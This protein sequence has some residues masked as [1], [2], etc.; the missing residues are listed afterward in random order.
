MAA[1]VAGDKSAFYECSFS[2][3]Q[4]TLADH[5]GRHYFKD[6]TIEGAID[7][8]FG[9]NGQSIYEVPLHVWQISSSLITCQPTPR[10][11]ACTQGCT[12][13]I[14]TSKYSPGFVTAQGRLKAADMGGFVFKSCLLQGSQSTYLGR[15]WGAYSRVIFFKTFMADVVVPQGWDAWYSK[16]SEWVY[17]VQLYVHIIIE[18][19][20]LFFYKIDFT[21]LH[22]SIH[23]I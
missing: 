4:D 2:G 15:A 10:L 11:Y 12:L 19:L 16:G 1:L 14:V 17:Y 22:A 9:I 20:I 3:I 5:Y 18:L 13:T 23:T 6:C 7:F 21:N 8:I